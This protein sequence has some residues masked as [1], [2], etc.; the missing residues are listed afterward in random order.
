MVNFEKQF[1]N[2]VLKDIKSLFDLGGLNELQD[3]EEQFIPKEQFD[4]RYKRYSDLILKR[5]ISNIVLMI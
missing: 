3:M 1:D 5:L 4:M 2:H